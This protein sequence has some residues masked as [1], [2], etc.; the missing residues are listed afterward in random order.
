MSAI[1]LAYERNR[2]IA[3]LE[4]IGALHVIAHM[5]ATKPDFWGVT[6]SY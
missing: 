1:N 6:H 2:A 5:P 3:D 4:G